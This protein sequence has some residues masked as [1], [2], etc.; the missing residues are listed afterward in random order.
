MDAICEHLEAVTDGEIRRLLINVPP[1]SSKSLLCNVFWPAWEWSMFPHLRYLS[2]SYAAHLTERDNRRFRDVIQSQRYQKLFGHKFSLVKKGEEYVS[3][4]KTGFKVA[5][6]I[7]GVG[8]GERGDRVILDDPHNVKEAESDVVRDGTTDWFAT[9]MS[10]RLNN[11]EKSAIVAIMQRVHES[12]VSGYILDKG[13]QYDHLCIP[14]EYEALRHCT[15]SIGWSDPRTEEVESFW[16]ERFNV[17][18]LEEQK[19]LMGP[20]GYAGQY[21]QRPSP[22]GGG[23][24][25][26]EWWQLWEDKAFPPLDYIVAYCDTAYTEKTMNDPSAMI[27]FG[28]FSQDA[29]AHANKTVGPYGAISWTERSYSEMIPKVIVMHAWQERLEFHNLVEKVRATA[30]KFKCDKVIVENKA[31]GIS[32]AQELRRVYGHEDFGVQ[33][34]DPKSQDKIARLHSI[35]HLFSEGLIYAPDRAWADMVI[36]QVEG[37]PTAKHDDL[38]D[39][40]SGGLR[41]LRDI[42]LLTRSIEKIAEIEAG[43]V[44]TGRPPGPLYPA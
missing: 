13:L 26:R 35:Q 2:F 25:K 36:T 31:S 41:H 34:N 42:G 40:I 6:S 24:I 1:G 44:Y 16:P 33:L 37:F 38:T 11:M 8:T 43:K 19:H 29:V 30:V 14:A 17:A 27:V 12:D 21:Q 15:T 3:N 28:V 39:C 20:Y 5:T 22:K 23:I 10:N 32:V 18:V 9:A 7:G 4:T